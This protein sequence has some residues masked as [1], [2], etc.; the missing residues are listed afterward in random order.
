MNRL[1]GVLAHLHVHRVHPRPQSRY[2]RC[3]PLQHLQLSPVLR[4]G[5]VLSPLRPVYYQSLSPFTLIHVQFALP[6]RLMRRLHPVA[7][8]CVVNVCSLLSGQL[9][10]VWE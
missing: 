3:L 1:T 10:L 2:D 4:S 6:H 7:I 5:H 8:S 9:Q